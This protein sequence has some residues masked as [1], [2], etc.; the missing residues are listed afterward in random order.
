MAHKIKGHGGETAPTTV[1]SRKPEVFTPTGGVLP[2]IRSG[3]RMTKREA[4]LAGKQAK[5][6]HKR[7][8]DAGQMKTANELNK[9]MKQLKELY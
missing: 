1:G 8:F 4:R 5:L 9:R 2:A 6:D 3:S 7:A